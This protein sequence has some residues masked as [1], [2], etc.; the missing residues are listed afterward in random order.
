MEAKLTLTATN[1]GVATIGLTVNDKITIVEYTE[2]N[3]SF[4]PPTPTAIGL[5]PKSSPAIFSDTTYSSA[6]TVV[7]GHDGSNGL[8]GAISETTFY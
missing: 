3:G 4:V 2:T 5:Y 7:Q 8:A 1:L 6:K